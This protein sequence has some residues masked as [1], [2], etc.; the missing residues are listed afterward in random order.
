MVRGIVQGVGFRP[1]VYRIASELGLAG[2][3]INRSDAVRVEVEGPAESVAAFEHQLKTEAPPLAVILGVEA[4]EITPLGDTGFRISASEIEPGS[5]T[6]IPPDI[7]TCADCLHEMF[8]P[9]DRRYLYPFLNCTNCGPR[10]TIIREVPYDRPAT[11]MV[12]FTMCAECER[13]YHD[14]ANRRF[15]AQPTA[16]PKCGPRVWFATAVEPQKEVAEAGAAIEAVRSALEQGQV[17]AV[18]GIGGFHLACDARNGKAVRTLR[19]RKGRHGKPLA[20]M[21]PDIEIARAWT[22]ISAQEEA[23]LASPRR[24]IVLLRRKPSADGP[25]DEVATGQA[26]LGLMLPY[27]PLHHLLIRERPL[28]MTSGNLSEE[29]IARDNDEAIERLGP[30]VDGFLLH[31]RGIHVVCDDSVVR[32]FRGV[33]LP[34]RRSRGHTP[35]PVVLPSEPPSILAVGGE[36]KATLCV[37]KAANAY[38]SQHIGDMANLETMQAFE[39]ALE[40][41]R[42]LFRTDPAMVACDM[43]PGY[44]STQWAQRYADRQKIP[45]IPV[46]HHHAHI[47]SVMAEHGLAGDASV[48]GVAWDGTGYGTDG[49]IWGGE[50]L[51]AGYRDFERIGYLRP[52]LLPGGDAAIK[53]P[54]RSALAHLF[55]AGL[56]WSSDL[57]CVV[58]CPQAELKLLR[59]QL[60][61]GLNCVPCTSMGRLFDALASLTGICQSTTYEAQPAM[62]LE[63]RTGDCSYKPYAVNVPDAFPLVLDPRPLFTSVI[64]DLRSHSSLETI[65]SRIH[66]TVTQWLVSGCRRIREHTGLDTVALSG[67][68][69]QNV[70]LLKQAVEKLEEDGFRVLTHR[71]VPPNDGGIALGQAAIAAARSPGNKH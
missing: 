32:V 16:C 13:E 39:R 36:L 10:F 46:Q 44:L 56:E 17:I 38:L 62:E 41:L 6:P 26:H 57:P 21:I 37:T 55:A 61:G 22:Q 64:A 45:L 65:A 25:A 71:L 69:F 52:I 43:H 60:E 66:A 7:A 19:E 33:E 47:S 53:R 42:S 12:D 4:V 54:Y 3:V 34:I 9:H 30:L 27:S 24:P 28:V 35:F 59:R 70:L 58:A 51:V 29:P 68:T 40:H 18:K 23:V 1:F 50:F 14:P 11:T 49:T 8:D 5:S 15:H 31:D 2:Y 67:G 20:V 48:V 63:A